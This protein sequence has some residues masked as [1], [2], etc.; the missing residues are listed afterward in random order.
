MG[1]NVRCVRCG[2]EQEGIL[3]S[4][5][6]AL[7]RIPE[8]VDYFTLLGEVPRPFLE[9]DSLREK[10]HKISQ[11]IHPDKFQTK[12]PEEKLL[13]EQWSSL[14]NKAFFTLKDP[15]ERVPYLVSLHTGE[16]PKK[17]RTENVSE[18]T[19]KLFQQVRTA[20]AQ[21][22]TYLGQRKSASYRIVAASLAADR[23]AET[24]IENLRALKQLLETMRARIIHDLK[25]IDERWLST[26]LEKRKNL[27]PLL[28]KVA[29]D[30]S[31]LAK[32]ESLIEERLLQLKV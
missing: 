25:R 32:F 21:A 10:H 15:T 26:D 31:R 7:L 17:A 14:L 20:C 18:W 4:N 1:I 19:V 23:A 30:L 13:A 24:Q 16:D 9:E 28:S 11:Q 12:S 8:R 22:D 2:A 3:C 6:G 5:C 29:G 27:I